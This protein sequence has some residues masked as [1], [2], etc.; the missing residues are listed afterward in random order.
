MSL[1]P[2]AVRSLVRS[3]RRKGFVEIQERE[4]QTNLFILDKLFA[5]LERHISGEKVKGGSAGSKFGGL[6]L[7]SEP[8][9][10]DCSTSETDPKSNY[11]EVY[12]YVRR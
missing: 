11:E 1:K 9:I 12:R 10:A 3:L 4:S 8:I 6:V 7:E 5:A 2:G